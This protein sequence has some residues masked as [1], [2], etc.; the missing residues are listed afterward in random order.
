MKFCSCGASIQN[1][2]KQCQPCYQQNRFKYTADTLKTAI[3]SSTTWEEVVR[4]VKAPDRKYSYIYIRQCAIQFGISVQHLQTHVPAPGPR[5]KYSH[6]YLHP[7][8]ER[9]ATWEQ[10][11]GLI[12][13][14][15]TYGNVGNLKSKLSKCGIDWTKFG[16]DYYP[17]VRRWRTLTELLQP[18][19]KV[20]SAYLRERLIREG[21]K[22]QKCEECG[23]TSWRGMPP[24]LELDHIDSN[25]MNNALE[26]LMI[27]CA[28]C[29]SVKTKKLRSDAALERKLGNCPESMF[30]EDY[31][32]DQW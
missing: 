23:I 32:D 12:S 16:T 21:V 28:N 7:L 20:V 2:A 9:A 24:P 25:P 4:K 30:E 18:N 19:S 14:Q 17:H 15:Y 13:L 5:V 31:I 3:E 1:R 22:D 11:C 27:R 26:N 6:D 10:L 29:H 8:V